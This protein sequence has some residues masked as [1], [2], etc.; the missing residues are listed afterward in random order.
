[1]LLVCHGS[2][3]VEKGWSSLPVPKAG[4]AAGPQK[5]AETLIT[6]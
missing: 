5:S 6:A 3:N 2:K 4:P 1:M